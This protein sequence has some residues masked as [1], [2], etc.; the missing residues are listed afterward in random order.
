MPVSCVACCPCMLPLVSYSEYA[1]G[2]DDGCQTVTLRFP[3]DAANRKTTDSWKDQ[4]S[5]NAV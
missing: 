2:T 1:D 3:L 5:Q 4:E